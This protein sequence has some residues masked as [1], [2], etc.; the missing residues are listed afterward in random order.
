MS[1]TLT[2]LFRNP[3]RC[4]FPYKFHGHQ[5]FHIFHK[6]GEFYE[7]LVDDEGV[8]GESPSSVDGAAGGAGVGVGGG[9]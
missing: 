7:K 1:Y 4:K 8:K 3:I 2:S 5:T 9:E 6:T